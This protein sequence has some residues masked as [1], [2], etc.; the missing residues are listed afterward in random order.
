M[1]WYRTANTEKFLN[2]KLAELFSVYEGD[3]TERSIRKAGATISPAVDEQIGDS[4]RK[5][6]PQSLFGGKSDTYGHWLLRDGTLTGQVADHEESA[7]QVLKA[8]PEYRRRI[9]G[10]TDLMALA[11]VIRVRLANGRALVL[12]IVHKPTLEQLDKIVE[13]GKMVENKGGV[14]MWQVMNQNDTGTLYEGMD[15]DS[16]FD[17]PWQR[18]KAF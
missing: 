18:L 10:I 9:D 8:L 12:D 1:S 14:V 16:I 15:V 13:L 7:N 6:H 2:A 17:V 11:G 3:W 5:N 4:L